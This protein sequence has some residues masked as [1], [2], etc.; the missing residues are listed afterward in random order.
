M[1][2]RKTLIA[3]PRIFGG[4]LALLLSG[5]LALP[6]FAEDAAPAPSPT[7]PPTIVAAPA[8]VPS[9]PFSWKVYRTSADFPDRAPVVHRLVGSVHLLP[10]SAYPLPSG[11][12]AAYAETSGLVLE[13]DPSALEEPE[14]QK[15]F[16]D[17][18]RAPNGLKASVEPALYELLQQ[19]SAKMQVP[20]ASAACEPFRAWFCA[21]SLELFRLQSQG[22]SG[23]LGL[24]RHFY[25]RALR[26]GRSV[27]WLEEPGAQLAIFSTMN[28]AQSAQFLEATLQGM[29][30]SGSDPADL[31]RQW[32]SNDQSTMER[33]VADMKRVYP[34]PYER[35]LGARNRAWIP[36]LEALFGESRPLMVVVGAAHLL[37]PDGLPVQLAARGWTVEPVTGTEAAPVPAPAKP[38]A[39][40][41]APL[42]VPVGAGPNKPGVAAKPV[43]AS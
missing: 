19:R 38:P 23:E 24:D 43:A 16:L 25:T 12:Q 13:T 4:A 28:D 7:A 22:V 20:A 18:A 42:L 33:T 32:R 30:E 41:P 26:D 3:K 39:D 1:P 37:G 2:S 14:F 27:R 40:Q 6:A 29:G 15:N 21:L 9:A 17:A 5:L 31:V 36:R 11:L 34:D 8:M 10:E 35:I